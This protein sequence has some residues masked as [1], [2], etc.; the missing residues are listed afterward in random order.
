MQLISL[1]SSWFNV[2]SLLVDQERWS[3]GVENCVDGGGGIE[4]EVAKFGPIDL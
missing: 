1:N 3:E 4:G 2:N